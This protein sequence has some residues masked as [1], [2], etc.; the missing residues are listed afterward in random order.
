MAARAADKQRTCTAY[1]R[2]GGDLAMTRCRTTAM[3]RGTTAESSRKQAP[4]DTA[5]AARRRVCE[6]HVSAT[7]NRLHE[8]QDPC[9]TPARRSRRQ[10]WPA[11][12]EFVAR[13]LQEGV[14]GQHSLAYFAAAS[15]AASKTLRCM[16]LSSIT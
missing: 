15:S 3:K 5:H 2:T 11:T 8:G 4:H 16:T 9:P 7:G 10:R 12:H 1:L 13:C 6:T 14:A